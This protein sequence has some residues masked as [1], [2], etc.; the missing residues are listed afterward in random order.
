MCALT[1]TPPGITS[2]SISIR[3]NRLWYGLPYQSR[4]ANLPL[5]ETDIPGNTF[6]L[7]KFMSAHPAIRTMPATMLSSVDIATDISRCEALGV[8]LHL[9][10]PVND[11]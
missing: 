7:A 5:I 6:D 8:P 11:A 2:T 9:R 10:K 4:L 3:D 1:P